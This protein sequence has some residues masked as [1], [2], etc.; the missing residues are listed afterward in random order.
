MSAGDNFWYRTLLKLKF[1]EVSG[2]SFQK[3][4]QDVMIYRYPDFESVQPHGNWGDGGNDGWFPLEKR[5]FQVYGPKASKTTE[6]LS[7]ITGK[8]T[9]DFDKILQKWPKARCYHFVYNDRFEGVPA[10][11]SQAMITLQEQYELEEVGVWNAG[12]LEQLFMELTDD[13]KMSI[14]GGVPSDVPNFIDPQAVSEL[15]THLA[16]KDSVLS[17]F[18]CES[19]P[20]FGGKIQL[21][22]LTQPVTDYIKFY[23]YQSQ[24]IDFFLQNRPGL[25]QSIAGE[26]K[27]IYEKSKEKIRKNNDGYPNI[28]YVWM[29]EELIPPHMKKHPHSL[30]AYRE[31]A[32]VV[33]A[34][35]F[36]T[37]DAYEH[38]D[39]ISTT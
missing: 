19:A 16:D 27:K 17:P 4:F 31:A 36:E 30:K 24:D 5:Y 10:P 18:L 38:P 6:S 22:G 34:K 29:V 1:Y 15:L 12:R 11:L 20:E 23:Y 37:C 7:T 8:I 14:I 28:R 25:T 32:Q 21:N 13:Q 26:I 9:G 3:L 35:Y 2:E 33:I 39:D